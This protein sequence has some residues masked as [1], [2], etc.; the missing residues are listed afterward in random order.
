MQSVNVIIFALKVSSQTEILMLN[1]NS[2]YHVGL[3]LNG[4]EVESISVQKHFPVNEC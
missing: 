2:L 4:Y 3:Y 1:N